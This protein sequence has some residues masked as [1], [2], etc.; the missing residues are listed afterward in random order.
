MQVASSM[1][2][3]LCIAVTLLILAKKHMLVS[4]VQREKKSL[5]YHLLV[6]L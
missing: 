5:L 2:I 6:S 1:F 3:Y 4:S